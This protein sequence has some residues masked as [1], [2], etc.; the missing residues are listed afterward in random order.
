MD[1][2]SLLQNLGSRRVFIT[3]SVFLG[4]ASLTPRWLRQVSSG[5]AC[6]GSIGRA[7]CIGDRLG[8]G[9]QAWE[10]RGKRGIACISGVGRTGHSQKSMHPFHSRSLTAASCMRHTSTFI[11]KL[12]HLDQSDWT[13]HTRSL[14]FLCLSVASCPRN[15]SAESIEPDPPGRQRQTPCPRNRRAIICSTPPIA[16][17]ILSRAA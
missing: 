13:S 2:Q 8:A 12:A 3:G 10:G 1:P 17:R 14:C 15:K 16:T 11:S 5:R 9:C 7:S 4:P 6:C